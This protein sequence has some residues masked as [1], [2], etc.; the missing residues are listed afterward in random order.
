[1]GGII[2]AAGKGSLEHYKKIKHTFNQLKNLPSSYEYLNPGYQ[3]LKLGR[4][5]D[6]HDYNFYQSSDIVVCAVGTF[7][8]KELGPKESVIKI[9]KDIIHGSIVADLANE[10]DGHFCIVILSKRDSK[11]YV[12]TDPS[13]SLHVYLY[14]NDHLFVLS[15]SMLALAK[16]FNVTPNINSIRH[17][18]GISHCLEGTTL[19]NE[20]E[21]LS[22]ASIYSIDL[23][24]YNV[25]NKAYWHPPKNSN[26]DL[27]FEEAAEKIKT[28]H[29]EQIVCK[30]LDIFIKVD[31]RKVLG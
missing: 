3:L 7:Y 22:P 20:I 11:A 1:M 2:F 4:M 17:F 23:N 9:A 26:Y 30:S 29:T 14:R 18:L 13:G 25:N 10:S 31:S 16:H 21:I 28:I 24:T 8:Y 5:Y 6:Q 15:T 19:F 12:I 27:T